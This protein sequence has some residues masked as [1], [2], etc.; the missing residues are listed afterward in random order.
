MHSVG[1]WRRSSLV[2]LR[3]GLLWNLGNR[4]QGP[5]SGTQGSPRS[6]LLPNDFPKSLCGAVPNSRQISWEM[7]P[8][9]GQM[10]NP[11]F[12]GRRRGLVR[13][14]LC[15]AAGAALLLE[16][17]A[18]PQCPLRLLGDGAFQVAQLPQGGRRGLGVSVLNQNFPGKSPFVLIRGSLKQASNQNIPSP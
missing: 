7:L 13:E 9:C 2:G 10:A 16:G 11:T 12:A 17:G 18:Q 4:F 3:T 1:K 6:L 14:G 5:L 15:R 8:P